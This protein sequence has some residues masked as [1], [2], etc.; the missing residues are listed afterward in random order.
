M[1]AIYEFGISNLEALVV[2]MM[3][4]VLAVILMIRIYHNK[5]EP[6]GTDFVKLNPVLMLSLM[7]FLISV[8]LLIAAFSFFPS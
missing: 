1:T 5:K 2:A 7:L 4:L 8:Y 6:I 3:C